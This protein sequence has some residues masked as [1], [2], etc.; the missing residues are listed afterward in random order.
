M[1]NQFAKA[2]AV[3]LGT[4]FVTAASPVHGQTPACVVHEDLTR[5][6]FPLQRAAQDIAAGKPFR[7]GAFASS[8]TSGAGASHPTL[9]YPAQL[10]TKLRVRFPHADITVIN[11]GKGGDTNAHM[12]ERVEEIIKERPQLVLFQTGANEVLKDLPLAEAQTQMLQILTRLRLLGIDVVMVDNQSAPKMNEK[13]SSAVV[14]MSVDSAA[15]DFGLP[16]MKRRELMR[17]WNE[18]NGLSYSVTLAPDGYHMTDWSYGCFAENFARGI[19]NAIQRPPV[20]AF[21][22]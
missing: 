19:T 13:A 4:A 14:Q 10:E 15:Y 5:F 11:R 8:T 20:V 21:R 9:T 1:S 16:Q 18:T 17:R 2:C 6:D 7:I 3:I 22:F 12:L